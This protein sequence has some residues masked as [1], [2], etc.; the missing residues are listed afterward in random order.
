MPR[1]PAV[2]PLEN[3]F[4]RKFRLMSKWMPLILRQNPPQTLPP[5]PPASE[6]LSVPSSSQGPLV[7][8]PR[9]LGS[10]SRLRPQPPPRLREHLPIRPEFASGVQTAFFSSCMLDPPLAYLGHWSHDHQRL[11]PLQPL[12][13]SGPA[14]LSPSADPP[15][16]CSWPTAVTV[17][18]SFPLPSP[19]GS[20][21]PR[22]VEG[23]RFGLVGLHFLTATGDDVVPLSPLFSSSLA[24]C[25][26]CDVNYDQMPR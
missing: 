26:G 18:F 3:P 11:C 19:F 2:P 4:Q 13:R 9:P 5:K 14:P 24:S 23:L 16:G 8:C 15:R 17:R 12:E 21:L 25:D 6:R 1:D 22:R 7:W 10:C 20:F